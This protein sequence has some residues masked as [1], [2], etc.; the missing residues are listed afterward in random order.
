MIQGFMDNNSLNELRDALRNELRLCGCAKGLDER[1]RLES[2][3]MT[4]VRFRTLLSDSGR[5]GTI[6]EEARQRSFGVAT[7]RSVNLVTNDWYMSHRTTETVRRYRL[8]V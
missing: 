6:L 2:A 3:H 8:H 1:Y 5:F 7:V 4:V